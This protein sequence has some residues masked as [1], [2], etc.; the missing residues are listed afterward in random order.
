M[1]S[2]LRTAGFLLCLI[3][4]AAGIWYL[5]R[6]SGSGRPP[7]ANTSNSRTARSRANN[8]A[9]AG[10]AENFGPEARNAVVTG[11]QA[12][13]APKP[14]V[15]RLSGNGSGIIRGAVRWLEDG[16]GAAGA[17]IVVELSDINSHSSTLPTLASGEFT[18]DAQGNYEVTGLGLGYYYVIAFSG[19]G[20][21]EISKHMG[22]KGEEYHSDIVLRKA[23][24]ISGR[25]VDDAKRPVAGAVLSPRKGRKGEQ[26]Q[27]VGGSVVRAKTDET[28]AFTIANL[29]E[30]EWSFVV[31][32]KEYAPCQSEFFPVGS[33]NAVIVL[34]AGGGVSG[35]VVDAATK[36]PVAGVRLVV[37]P[38]VAIW[39]G[40]PEAVSDDNGAFSLEHLVDDSYALRLAEKESRALVGPQPK[41]KIASANRAASLEVLVGE[42]GVIS[43]RIY[44]AET[45][46]PVEGV[47]MEADPLDNGFLGR[48]AKTDTDGNYRIQGLGTGIHDVSF[49]RKKGYL[50]DYQLA[51]KNVNV[52]MGRESS[53]V[54]FPMKRC[55]FV[56]GRVID[57]DGEPISQ[58]QI[59]ARGE[60]NSNMNANAFSRQ[61]GSFE[62]GGFAPRVGVLL[63]VSKVEFIGIPQFAVKIAETD[64]NDVE[65]RM[66]RGGRISGVLVD[67]EGA[68]VEGKT[69][70]AGGDN[71]PGGGRATDS[72]GNFTI[73]GLPPGQYA[74]QI[75]EPYHEGP[76][77]PPIPAGSVT[78]TENQDLTGLRLVYTGKPALPKGL[79]IEGRITNRKNEPIKGATVDA[80]RSD[81]TPGFATVQSDADG[82]FALQG[83]SKGQ[84]RLNVRHENYVAY[85][86]AE[87]AAGSRNI[88]VIL[89]SSSVFEGRVVDAKTG[90]PI[91][92]FLAN[93][94]PGDAGSLDSWARNVSAHDSAL[95]RFTGAEGAFRLS[96]A[97]TDKAVV[98]A[99]AQGYGRGGIALDGLQPGQTTS[100]LTI[101]LEPGAVI[102]GVVRDESGKAITGA[103]LWVSA[104]P[105]ETPRPEGGPPDA[106]APPVH[107]PDEATDIKTDAAGAYRLEGL[108]GQPIV[109]RADHPDYLSTAVAVTPIQGRSTRLDM[110]MKTGAVMKGTVTVGGSPASGITVS[111][112]APPTNVSKRATTDAAGAYIIFG[113]PATEGTVSANIPETKPFLRRSVS[114]HVTIEQNAETV[115]NLVFPVGASSL[116]G[117]ITVDGKAPLKA[118]LSISTRAEGEGLATYVLQA[119]S[120]GLFRLEGLAA[121]TYSADIDTQDSDG[122]QRRTSFSLEVGASGETRR[123][124]DL[125]RWRRP[126]GC[127]TLARNLR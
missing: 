118:S 61:D 16:Q 76:Q 127:H 63:R 88:S 50:Y 43:G 34:H 114:A 8:D 100:G 78:I 97:I 30:G 9:P 53:G 62:L 6:S 107:T 72:A 124:V 10:S 105:I 113:L 110:V 91:V 68:P 23:G 94:S 89:D 45:N 2:N 74:M 52:E 81:R 5:F 60:S 101:R 79:S 75:R 41:F 31:E 1:S 3:L 25:V 7:A 126:C 13:A 15:P 119:N 95:T 71:Q 48:Q 106:P 86:E 29:Y 20:V 69:V 21:G 73:G 39:L 104:V 22:E 121:G 4:A 57:E 59:S 55:L 36:A 102:E 32:S 77:E 44:D 18:A 42:G 80:S 98:V 108:S 47:A 28:G 27:G 92:S 103:T 46:E 49:R 37:K 54:D 83:L 109:V 19:D 117:R 40:E 96:A 14:A 84:Y 70:I 66:K 115:V 11:K 64:L 111:I 67:T 112:Y 35:T 87:V 24:T 125:T 58:A 120:T 93:A 17:R 85:P 33:Q 38:E 51:R 65:V 116:T 99:V 82:R 122:K 90:S 26:E 56:R 12:N 123:D